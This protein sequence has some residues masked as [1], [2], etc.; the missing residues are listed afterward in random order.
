MLE[1]LAHTQAG[2]GSEACSFLLLEI[3]MGFRLASV[4]IF[5][6]IMVLSTRNRGRKECQ[7]NIVRYLPVKEA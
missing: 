5:L 3:I 6:E 2:H 4:E 1:P 7:D